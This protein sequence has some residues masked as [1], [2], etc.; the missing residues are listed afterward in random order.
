MN[1]KNLCLSTSVFARAAAAALLAVAALTLGVANAAPRALPDGMISGVVKSTKGAE[2]GVW[3]IAE[4]NDLPTKLHQDRRDRRPRPLRAAGT[5]ERQL[6]HL[7]ARLRS[8][9][10]RNR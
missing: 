1:S 8:R 9:P 2:A 6:Q 5:A 7:G 3:V 10:I 4:T